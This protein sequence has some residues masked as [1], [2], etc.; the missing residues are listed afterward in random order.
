MATPEIMREL[1]SI[2]TW[3]DEVSPTI[4]EHSRRIAE[5]ETQIAVRDADMRWIKGALKIIA[6]GVASIIIAMIP[7]LIDLLK[8]GAANHW[9]Y[10]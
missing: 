5:V 6:A 10:R 7:L 1:Q 8:W 4:A 9:N 2:Q 3:R